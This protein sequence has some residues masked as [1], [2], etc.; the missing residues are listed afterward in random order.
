M[1]II[2]TFISGNRDD[3]LK[4]IRDFADNYER[5]T[6]TKQEGFEDNMT[7]VLPFGEYQYDTLS[8]KTQTHLQ[9]VEAV[10]KLGVNNKTE[11]N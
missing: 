5:S 10:L 3:M 6:A 11:E 4:L 9:S 8:G 1:K 7:A 2:A